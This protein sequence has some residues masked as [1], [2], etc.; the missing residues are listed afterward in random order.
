MDAL[1]D[2][3][4]VFKPA[5]GDGSQTVEVS[6]SVQALARSIASFEGIGKISDDALIRSKYRVAKGEHD[7]L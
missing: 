3:V 6:P 5:R 4:F 7:A 1:L 2:P